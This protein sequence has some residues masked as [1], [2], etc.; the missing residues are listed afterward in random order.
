MFDF[1]CAVRLILE[2]WEQGC[3]IIELLHALVQGLGGQALWLLEG[4]IHILN[5]TLGPVLVAHRQ[6]MD[7]L[8]VH[9]RLQ[10]L[11]LFFFGR[12]AIFVM[13]A[14]EEAVLSDGIV[15]I[16]TKSRISHLLVE[17]ECLV[18]DGIFLLLQTVTEFDL[19]L[20]GH[21]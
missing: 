15:P 2:S 7:A 13:P 3:Q 4:H 6:K 11:A 8:A 17:S 18:D 10:I 5:V 14:G 16:R 20:S 21:F 19:L 12:L 1:E 9:K